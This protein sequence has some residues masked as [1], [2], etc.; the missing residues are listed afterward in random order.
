MAAT[1]LTAP[2]LD[3]AQVYAPYQKQ[4]EFLTSRA[5][6][7]LFLAGR[8]AGKSWTLT[9][10]AVVQA[11]V[12][13]GVEGA[14]LGRTERD[15][16]KV[17]LP[18]LRIHFRTLA[19]ATGFNWIRRFSA[20]DQAIYL[21]NGSTI[22][23]QGFERI[24]KLRGFNLGWANADEFCWSET[25]EQTVYETLI[26][27]IRVP[28]PRPGFAGAS[29]P[30]GLRGVVKL[31]RDKQLLA[32]PKFYCARAT[33]YHNPYLDREV[34]DGWK[35]SMSVRRYEQEVLALALRPMS[36]VY[37]E[38][39]ED[40]HIVPWSARH[41]S[42]CR[43]VIGVDWGLNRAVAVAIQVTPDG[44]W[45]VAAELVREPE[46]RGH[47][48]ADFKQWVD[49][50]TGAAAPFL[51]APDRAI[52]E[53]NRWLM[54]IYG[55]KK[56]H[57]MPLT[58]KHDQYVRNGIAEIQ[59]M[60]NPVVGEPRLMFAHALP[61]LFD[62]NVAGIVPSMSAYRYT[63]D[64]DGTP[65]DVPAKDNTHDHAVDALRY[66]VVAG[67]RFK[68]LHA[69]RLPGRHLLGPDGV[70]PPTSDPQTRS[71][72]GQNARGGDGD[73]RPHW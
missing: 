14:L 13:P 37:G 66:A 36:A 10:D 64:R 49:G 7:R 72:D 41:H 32:D 6:N 63:T 3:L 34:I 39:R 71:P 9:L 43:W 44:R 61:R 42:E 15:L 67:S 52:P 5:R 62:G 1:E 46:S 48:R 56:T 35:A 54:Q 29:S 33:S 22:F 21:H 16:K 23:W 73:W 58:S 27:C 65:T 31:F 53:E 11:L 20:D 4:A 59:D 17:L 28:C 69:G 18:F 68:E 25:D 40:R 30:N 12:N 24:D 51:I 8:G 55:V 47:F 2:E 60:L 70:H 50:L 57:V 45:Y 26:G 38:F 19:D